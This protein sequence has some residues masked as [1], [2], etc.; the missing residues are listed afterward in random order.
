[1]PPAEI[2]DLSANILSLSP[3]S[4][5]KQKCEFPPQKRPYPPSSQKEQRKSTRYA[6]CN[7]TEACYR[8]EPG[9]W[10]NA[11]Q[12]EAEPKVL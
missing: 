2:R 5:S 4:Y 7:T 3:P 11:P 8:A 6:E 10:S 9:L 12:H 1:M